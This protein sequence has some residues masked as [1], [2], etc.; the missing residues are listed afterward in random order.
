MSTK[1]TQSSITTSAHFTGT[2]SQRMAVAGA[3]TASSPRSTPT[4]ANLTGRNQPRHEAGRGAWASRVA[5][6][7]LSKTGFGNPGGPGEAAHRDRAHEELEE[8]GGGGQEEGHAEAGEGHDQ[9]RHGGADDPRK[10]L[11]LHVDASGRRLKASESDDRAPVESDVESKH[12]GRRRRGHEGE[13][14]H[15]GAVEIRR[16]HGDILMMQPRVER[17]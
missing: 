17:R 2:P 5:E 8:H 16:T 13:F 1:S 10:A 4:P 12:G 6:A 15:H 11:R 9:Q 14:P 7:G 3:T